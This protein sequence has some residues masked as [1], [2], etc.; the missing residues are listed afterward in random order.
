MTYPDRGF[1]VRLRRTARPVI[2]AGLLAAAAPAT[3]SDFAVEVVEYVRG[4]PVPWD[5]IYQIPFDEPSAALGRPTVDT[6]DDPPPPGP[7]TRLQTVVPVYPAFRVYPDFVTGEPVYEL[8]SIG[9]GGHLILRFDHPV[10]ND[11]RNPAGID[12]IVFGNYKCL[13]TGGDRWTDGDPRQAVISANM[14]VPE[15]GIVSVSQ[16]G[17]PGSWHTFENRPGYTAP[18]AD[19]WAPTLGRVYREPVPPETGFWGQPTDPTLPLNPA[20]GP[21]SFAGLTVAEA[22]R[23]YGHSAGGTGFDLSDVGLDWIQYVRI[24]NPPGSSRTPEIDAVSDVRPFPFPDLDWDTDVDADDISLFEACATG[25]GAGPVPPNCARA[26]F[27]GDG[28]I[29]QT[30]FGRLQRCLTGPDRLADLG[31]MEAAS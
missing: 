1:R 8:V 14:A 31:C 20:L 11:P 5:Y 7:E 15:E 28:D 13:L 18:K 23:K 12:F 22:A 21:G 30:D 26:D 17:L 9:A 4:G 27:D 19:G 3:A 24:E 25:P 29:D 10:E 2:L 16:T 6:T